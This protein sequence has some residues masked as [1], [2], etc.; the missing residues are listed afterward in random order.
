MSTAEYKFKKFFEIQHPYYYVEVMPHNK[1]KGGHMHQVGSLSRINSYINACS[2]VAVLESLSGVSQSDIMFM[3][4]KNLILRDRSISD[5][6]T[7]KRSAAAAA[8]GSGA[9]QY[10]GSS[11]KTS[12]QQCDLGKW[13]LRYETSK[14]VSCMN[15][16]FLNHITQIKSRLPPVISEMCGEIPELKDFEQLFSTSENFDKWV[17]N[18][19]RIS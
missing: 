7:T 3:D 5:E 8:S 1:I 9:H 16:F 13:M 6:W 18:K 12:Y 10:S 19:H 15:Q 17:L 4:S 14:Q 2:R 11:L